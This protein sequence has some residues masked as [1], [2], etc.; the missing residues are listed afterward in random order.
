MWIV[1]DDFQTY[2]YNKKENAVNKAKEMYTKFVKDNYKSIEEY[3]NCCWGDTYDETMETIEKENCFL[4]DVV[5]IYE[6][7]TED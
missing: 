7:E 6:I 1:K 5:D 3:N 2:Y 4:S